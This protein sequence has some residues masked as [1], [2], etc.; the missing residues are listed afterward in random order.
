MITVCRK[1]EPVG[2]KQCSKCPKTIPRNLRVCEKCKKLRHTKWRSVYNSQRPST[3]GS[4]RL[5][6][7]SRMALKVTKFIPLLPIGHPE[8]S[9]S[10]GLTTGSLSK[11]CITWQRKVPHGFRIMKRTDEATSGSVFLD[12]GSSNGRPCLDLMTVGFRGLVG[13]ELSPLAHASAYSNLHRMMFDAD[14]VKK[15]KHKNTIFKSR[16]TFVRGDIATVSS[17]RETPTT[18]I[19]RHVYIKSYMMLFVDS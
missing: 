4:T 18:H 9:I 6:S 1:V 5:F 16:V 7:E 10:G 3:T 17:L 19:Y 8:S 14:L 12:I 2:Y 13:I 15:R 11:L